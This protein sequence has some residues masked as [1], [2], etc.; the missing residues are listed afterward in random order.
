VARRTRR[1]IKLLATIQIV[2]KAEV[3]IEGNSFSSIK[4]GILIF[5]CIEQNDNSTAVTE[6]V[7][8]IINF[9]MLEGP[10]GAIS[11]SLKESSEE[12][13]IVSQ[14]TLAAIT[15]DGNKPSFHKAAKPSEAKLLYD[16]FVTTFSKLFSRVKTGKF[17]AYMDISITNKGPVTFNFKT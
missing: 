12:V 14:F 13:L 11:R 6:M 3:F 4:N 8:R 2:S 7:S 5:V 9:R 10:K 16:E 1:C 15:D 17:G